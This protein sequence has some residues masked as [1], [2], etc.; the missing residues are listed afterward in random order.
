MT[1]VLVFLFGVA[2]GA[3]LGYGIAVLDYS[4]SMAERSRA[5]Y[6]A[7]LRGDDDNHRE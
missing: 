6:L 4:G 2:L 7:M 3:V 5:R 1:V